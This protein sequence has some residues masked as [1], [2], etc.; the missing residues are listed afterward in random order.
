MWTV[1]L[2]AWAQAE[3]P[4]PLDRSSKL[5]GEDYFVEGRRTLPRG[6]KLVCL[7]DVLIRGRGK[8][9]TLVIEGSLETQGIRDHEVV[10]KDVTVELAP[11]Y[12]T[13][14]FQFTVFEGT[15]RLAT[16]KDKPAS[17]KLELLDT[18]FEG[19]ARFD[20]AFSHGAIELMRT[21]SVQRVRIR[22]T[23][24]KKQLKFH[25]FSSYREYENVSGLHGG[26]EIEGVYDARVRW[27]R[28]GGDLAK[29]HNCG[30][31]VLEACLLDADTVQ[32]SSDR[33]GRLAKTKFLK[34]DV[35]SDTLVFRAPR[36]K[37]KSDRITLANC[38]FRGASDAKSVLRSRVE[39][40]KHV[41]V[42]VK[43][44]LKSPKKLS[45]THRDERR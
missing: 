8:G 21:S 13:A 40:P 12:Q 16:G 14:R 1:L 17:G 37:G 24:P 42:T 44:L 25:C 11:A 41:K 33:A 35:Y 7:K 20:V 26:F 30:A 32:L 31:V 6:F 10:F 36:E 3:E 43:S 34:C 22:G 4:L 2:V 38:Y 45:G 19:A 15:A 28:V 39:A 9:A 27:T 18:H 23:D 29:F 5:K